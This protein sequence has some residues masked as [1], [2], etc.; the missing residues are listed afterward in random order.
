[1]ILQ[2]FGG[3]DVHTFDSGRMMF[4]D[5][6][7]VG[8]SGWLYWNMV[9]DQNGGPWVV[10]P[11]H[12]DPDQNVQQ[13]LIVVNTDAGT[14]Q[15]TGAYY[16]MAHTGHFVPA[17]QAVRVQA[18]RSRN[19]PSNLLSIAWRM[20]D[21]MAVILMNDANE[22]RTVRLQFRGQAAL[23]TVSPISYTTLVFAC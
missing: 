6:N 16:A 15:P 8:A 1:V 11:E 3:F 17:G 18:S 2:K 21:S 10:S 12:D 4:A 7:I 14:W 22:S 9:L 20:S 23:V 5:F 19:A 13:P